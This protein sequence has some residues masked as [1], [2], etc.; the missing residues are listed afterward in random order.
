MAPQE[1]RPT[2]LDLA[3]KAK[4]PN[5]IGVDEYID[6][7]R[8]ARTEPILAVNL[9]TRGPEEAR[10]L[11]E[12]CNFPGGSTWSDLRSK[13]GHPQPHGIRTWC[14]GNELDGPWQAYAKT[15]TEYGRLAREAAK[16]MR[17]IDD[18]IELIVCGS[19]NAHMATFG[20]WDCKVG[21]EG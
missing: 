6:W 10:D 17:W 12:Y 19:S 21:G 9:G 11:V 2:R 18:S 8:A 14:L 15:P 5:G 20:E 3:W 4:E 16:L 1:G 13:Y 7:C